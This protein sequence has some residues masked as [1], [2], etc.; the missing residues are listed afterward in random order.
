MIQIVILV[1]VVFITWLASD[2]EGACFMAILASFVAAAFWLPFSIGDIANHTRDGSVPIR[3]VQLKSQDHG[4]LS[5]GGSFLGW[6]V[7][8]GSPS[9]VVME[10]VD[11]RMIRR[12]LPQESTYVVETDGEPRVEYAAYK[13]SYCKLACAPWLINK[14]KSIVKRSEATIYVPKGTVVMKFKEIE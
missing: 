8:Q 14:T 11:G 12:F 7:S 3:I 5:G 2:I 9:Y 10:E 1:M 4:G 6:H 13:V